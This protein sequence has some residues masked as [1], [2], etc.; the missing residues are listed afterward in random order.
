MIR[1]RLERTV[2]AATVLSDLRLV[3][4]TLWTAQDDR[5]ERDRKP[6]KAWLNATPG[7]APG[8]DE[9]SWT[10]LS[11]PPPRGGESR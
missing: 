8:I 4:I 11:S 7:V 10:S 6:L 5:L 2:P 3:D 1:R 9:V